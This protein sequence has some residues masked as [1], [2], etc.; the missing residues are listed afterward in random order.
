[1][2]PLIII[3]ALNASFHP[4][5]D[6]SN[7]KSDE[8][9]KEPSIN[10]VK[11][12]VDSNFLSSAAHTAYTGI[13][14]QLWTAIDEEIEL[15]NCDIYSYNPDHNSDPFGEEGC[16]W[17]FNY[18]FYNRKLKRILFFSCKASLKDESRDVWERDESMD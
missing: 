8:F 7:A 2:S 4:D 18:L 3:T 6:F 12:A 14:G 9:S 17:S 5:Y 13:R 15:S 16:L 10:W 11:N 1:M